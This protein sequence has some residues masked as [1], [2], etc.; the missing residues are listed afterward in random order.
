MIS[1]IPDH[2]GKELDDRGRRKK[3]MNNM[4]ITQ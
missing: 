3:N 4:R 2:G 1:K